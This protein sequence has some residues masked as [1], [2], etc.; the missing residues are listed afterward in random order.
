MS[1]HWA[2]GLAATR[3]WTSL[4][5]EC[6]LDHP[7]GAP[8]GGLLQEKNHLKGT[9]GS[10]FLAFSSTWSPK[11]GYRYLESFSSLAPAKCRLDLVPIAWQATR[12]I[13]GLVAPG[14]SGANGPRGLSF[15]LS[16]CHA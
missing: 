6:P 7:P 14:D 3:E 5:G 1:V 2:S 15:S 13:L 11:K 16:I 9:E 4:I 12:I 10:S 8:P